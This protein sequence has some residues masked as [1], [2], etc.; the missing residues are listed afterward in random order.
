MATSYRKALGPTP[1][2][3][4]D[5]ATTSGGPAIIVHNNSGTAVFIGG[6]DVTASTG[7]SLASGSALGFTI[8][9]SEAVYGVTNTA[10]LTV[11]VFRTNPSNTPFHA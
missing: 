6:E 11:Q 2:L 10:T 3:I 1:I 4:A 9:G 7:F 5:L 8:D